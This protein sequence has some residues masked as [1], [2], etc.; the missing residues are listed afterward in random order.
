MPDMVKALQAKWDEWNVLNVDPL[1]GGDPT[2]T[3]AAAAAAKKKK[4]P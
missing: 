4:T 3:N 1:W 2:A